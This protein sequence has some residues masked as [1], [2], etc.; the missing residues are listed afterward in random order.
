[1][2]N[3]IRPWTIKNISQIIKVSSGNFSGVSSESFEVFKSVA[4]MGLDW[5]LND[6]GSCVLTPS[7]H[8]RVNYPI[9]VMLRMVIKCS[10]FS[11][12]LQDGLPWTVVPDKVNIWENTCKLDLNEFLIDD[13]ITLVLEMVHL[14]CTDEINKEKVEEDEAIIA[15]IE[16]R[17]LKMFKEGDRTDFTI[18]VDDREINCHKCVLQT[19]SSIFEERDENLTESSLTL[20]MYDYDCIYEFVLFMYSM[21]ETCLS[22]KKYAKHFLSLGDLYKVRLLKAAAESHLLS[23]IC[24]ANARSYAWLGLQYNARRLRRKA[25]DMAT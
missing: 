16:D 11:Y 20:N 18:I 14:I 6:N 24:S 10:R 2:N 4:K 19:V 12:E 5:T 23:T 1:M 25:E 21:D 8:L 22:L 7:V 17:Y 15:S 9:N 13:S 3:F